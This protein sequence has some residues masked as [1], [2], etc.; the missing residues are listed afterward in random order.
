MSLF[1]ERTAS[2]KRIIALENQIINLKQELSSSKGSPQEASSK[3]KTLEEENLGLKKKLQESLASENLLSE[4]QN[5]LSESKVEVSELKLDLKKVRSE[6]TRLKKK[7]AKVEEDSAVDLVF[8]D[9]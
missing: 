4:I 5:L 3:L 7:L 9:S 8:E 2:S 6:N 1:K